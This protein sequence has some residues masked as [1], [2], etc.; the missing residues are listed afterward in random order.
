MH[1]Q[2][3]FSEFC[4]ESYETEVSHKFVEYLKLCFRTYSPPLA[5]LLISLTSHP[6]ER[7]S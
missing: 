2:L 7:Y 1:K 5:T 4:G 6:S 3:T